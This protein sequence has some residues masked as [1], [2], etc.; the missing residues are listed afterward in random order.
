MVKRFY[1]TY[2]QA[3]EKAKKEE[4]ELFVPVIGKGYII[5]KKSRAKK[6]TLW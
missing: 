5:T 3:E 4:K 1:G 2:K 6:K